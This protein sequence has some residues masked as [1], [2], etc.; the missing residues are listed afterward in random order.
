MSATLMPR[1][2]SICCTVCGEPVKDFVDCDIP[3]ES[4]FFFFLRVLSQFCAHFPTVPAY[5]SRVLYSKYN[6]FDHSDNSRD[7]IN[8][9][10][11]AKDVVVFF[12]SFSGHSRTSTSITRYLVKLPAISSPWE[13]ICEEMHRIYTPAQDMCD[14]A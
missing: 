1:C 9:V 7:S 3:R 12:F 11:Y 4:I 2:F 13:K 5:K 6:N 10:L 8:S 14:F